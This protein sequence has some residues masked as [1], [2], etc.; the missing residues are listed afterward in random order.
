MPIYGILKGPADVHLHRQGVAGQAD[1]HTTSFGELQVQTAGVRVFTFGMT[2]GVQAH[3][4][5]RRAAML[6]AATPGALVA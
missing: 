1:I 5:V 2:G 3:C 6:A 4:C